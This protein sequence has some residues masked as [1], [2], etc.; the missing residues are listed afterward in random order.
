MEFEKKRLKIYLN[1]VLDVNLIDNKIEIDKKTKFK[2]KYMSKFYLIQ[3]F[4]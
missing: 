4:K 2:F 3:D 1:I